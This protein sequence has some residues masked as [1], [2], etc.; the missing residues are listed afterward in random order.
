MHW[1]VMRHL[2][3][4]ATGVVV[5]RLCLKPQFSSFCARVGCELGALI[6][7]VLYQLPGAL[8]RYNAQVLGPSL[9]FLGQPAQAIER[10]MLRQIVRSGPGLFD[11]I[12]HFACGSSQRG[13]ALLQ[14]GMSVAPFLHKVNA[15]YRRRSGISVKV[16][17]I[18]AIVSLV[19]HGYPSGRQKVFRDA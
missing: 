13:R 14:R 16:G 15:F 18:G 12:H 10:R 8:G 19:G 4:T 7:R 6:A 9:D 2:T 3:G 5:V 11:H 17:A 1:I